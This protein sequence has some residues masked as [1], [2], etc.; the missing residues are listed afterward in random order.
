ML[1]HFNRAEINL[2]I[3]LKIPSLSFKP[4]RRKPEDVTIKAGINGTT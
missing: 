3:L 2:I 1:S 4:N